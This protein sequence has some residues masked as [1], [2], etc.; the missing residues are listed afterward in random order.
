MPGGAPAGAWGSLPGLAGSLGI[1][2]HASGSLKQGPIKEIIY[3]KKKSACPDYVIKHI[4]AGLGAHIEGPIPGAS[5]L[6]APNRR[7]HRDQ[8][9]RYRLARWIT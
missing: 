8:R 3:I 4:Y 6:L 5:G 1:A 2:M 7:C 9:Q